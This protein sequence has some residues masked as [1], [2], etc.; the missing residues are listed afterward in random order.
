MPAFVSSST[1]ILS[2]PN[3]PGIAPRAA[4]AIQPADGGAKK[5]ILLTAIG[6]DWPRLSAVGRG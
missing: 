1:P 4:E 3:T 2:L 5:N 6:R